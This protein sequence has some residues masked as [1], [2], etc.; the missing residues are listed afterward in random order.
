MKAA[1]VSA[2][3]NQSGNCY[4]GLP[5]PEV[6]V[7]AILNGLRR[8]KEGGREK[9]YKTIRGWISTS[10]EAVFLCVCVSACTH[11]WC[12]LLCVNQE[13]GK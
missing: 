10:V 8:M 13:A 6:K 7:A 11:G 4:F 5:R 1:D 2:V 12:C 9:I 3:L